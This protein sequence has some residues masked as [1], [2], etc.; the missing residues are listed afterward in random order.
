VVIFA[1][2]VS[3]NDLHCIHEGILIVFMLFLV[4][5]SWNIF[6]GILMSVC[7]AVGICIRSNDLCCK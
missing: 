7:R 1:G 4:Y 6:I 2:V 5:E 3:Y